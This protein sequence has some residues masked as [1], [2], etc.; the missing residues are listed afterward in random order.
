MLGSLNYISVRGGIK[1]RSA[2][3]K[4]VRY[5]SVVLSLNKLPPFIR[6]GRRRRYAAAADKFDT[7]PPPIN[8]DRRAEC[9][10]FAQGAVYKGRPAN[11]EGWF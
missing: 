10:I 2:C 5:I 6:R 3:R 7:P 9:Q 11:G 4:F 1:I 8:F